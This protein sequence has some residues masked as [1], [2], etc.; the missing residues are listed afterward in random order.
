LTLRNK[1]NLKRQIM[2]KY[3]LHNGNKLSLLLHLKERNVSVTFVS[4]TRSGQTGVYYTADKEI[5]DAL[6]KNIHFNK[7]FYKAESPSSQ[8]S[9]QVGL[10]LQPPA[11]GL[12]T[13]NKDSESLKDSAGKGNDALTGVKQYPD[14]IHY[15]SAVKVLKDEYATEVANKTELLA[16][17]SELKIEFPNLR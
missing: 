15:Q 5:Q 10:S 8:N 11:E 3:Q 12:T 9:P 14:V 17:A 7:L 16:A 6:E 1:N 2:Q 4:P 13:G